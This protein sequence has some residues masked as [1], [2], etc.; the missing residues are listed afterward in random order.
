MS[1]TAEERTE[2]VND[3]SLLVERPTGECLQVPETAW[4]LDERSERVFFLPRESE[5]L[6]ESAQS[7]MSAQNF[8]ESA[9]PTRVHIPVKTLTAADNMGEKSESVARIIVDVVRYSVVSNESNH[10]ERVHD[11]KPGIVEAWW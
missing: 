11:F 9:P 5:L 1:R 10:P 8:V 3:R 6:S 2:F 4:E 7:R